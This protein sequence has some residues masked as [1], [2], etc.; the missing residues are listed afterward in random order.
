MKMKK[1]FTL[2]IAALFCQVADAQKNIGINYQAV[3]RDLQGNTMPNKELSIKIS[4]GEEDQMEKQ[5]YIE[6][7]LVKTN[8]LGIFYIV[9]GKGQVSQ[10]SFAEIPWSSNDVWMELSIDTKAGQD[11]SVVNKSQLLAVPYAIHALTADQIS[12]PA[13]NEHRRNK[14]GVPSNVWSTFGNSKTSPTTDFLGTTDCADLVMIT[15]NE[16][17]LRITC[18]GEVAIDKDLSVGRDLDVHRNANLNISG[19]ETNI[20]GATSVR[21]MSPTYLSGILTVDKQ[22]LLNSTLDVENATKLKSTLSVDGPSRLNSSLNVFGTTVLHENTGIGGTLYNNVRLNISSPSSIDYPLNVEIGSSNARMRLNNQ[23]QL[24]LTST[25][26]GGSNNS[27]N[28]GFRLDGNDQGMLIRL[29]KSYPSSSNNYMTFAGRSGNSWT[30]RGRIEGQTLGEY[31][32]D[33]LT[34]AKEVYTAAI[35]VAEGIAIGTAIAGAPIDPSAIVSLA[36]QLALCATQLSVEL[37]NLGVSYASGSGDYAE[38]LKREHEQERMSSA[39]IVGVRGG[40]ISKNT[41]HAD[42]FMVISTSPIVLGNMPEAEE[43][44]LFEKVAFMGQ[45]PVKVIGSVNI[46]DYIL[47]SGLNDGL[48]VAVSPNSMGIMDYQNIVGVAWSAKQ[49]EFVGFVNLAVGINSNDIVNKMQSELTAIK[50]DI[51]NIKVALGL[52]PA[53]E[54]AH[55]AEM[56][57]SIDIEEAPLNAEEFYAAQTS[58]DTPGYNLN[59]VLA[60]EEIFYRSIQTLREGFASRGYDVDNHPSLKKLL[61]DRAYQ[62]EIFKRSKN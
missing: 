49:D 18:A 54:T 38:Y 13:S 8:E 44:H 29:D 55:I 16:E 59:T 27:G 23:G 32:S 3:A 2:L 11:F 26:G 48:G 57:K 35:A 43:A 19:G 20:Y 5:N 47:P 33:P 17:Q 61:N 53:P 15:D 45:V 12:D 30:I 37:S 6:T 24:Y 50:K 58:P 36:A 31:Q 39:D 22:T 1:I 56:A 46:G 41:A 62:Q 4:L 60:S 52:G 40:I 25:K 7:H 42:H 21:N 10:G 14:N 9:V 28:Y 34:I 51:A